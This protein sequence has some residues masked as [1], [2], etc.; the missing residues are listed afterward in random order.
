MLRRTLILTLFLAFTAIGVKP[1]EAQSDRWRH[2]LTLVGEQQLPEGFKH[3]DYVNPQ[4]PKA[5]VVRLG[6]QGTFDSFNLVV[7]GLRGQ[8]QSGVGL[9]YDTL[10]TQSQDE[11]DGAYGLLAEAVRYPDD[12]SSVTYRLR[13]SARWHDGLP[14]TSEDVIFS[15]EALKA[16]SPMFSS[17]YAHVTSAVASGPREITFSFSEKGNRELPYVVGQLPVLPK[18]WWQGT[19][20]AGKKRDITQSS[21]EPPLGS[22][23]YR[24]K[25]FEPGRSAVYERVAD[26]WG[27]DIP[28]N[29]GQNNFDEVSYEY[30]RDSTVLLEAFKA[31]RIDFRQENIARNWATA[32]DFPAALEGRVIKEEFPSRAMGIMQ[33]MVFNLRRDKFVDER[34]RQAFNLAFDFEE[35]NKILF[36]GLYERIDSYFFGTELASSGLPEGQELAILETVRDKV[37]ARI[38]STPFKNPVNG[39]P[40]AVRNNLREALDLMRQAGYELRGRQLVNTKTGQPF[41]AEFLTDDP[42]F[43]R[44]ALMYKQALEKIGISVS[45]RT[46]D[47]AQYQ[48][49]LRDFDFD[50][51]T[52][53]WAQTLS[54]GNEQS[55]FWGSKS[56]NSPGSRNVVGINNPAVD[57]L[58]D[59]VVF[60]KDRDELVAA[61]HALDRVLLA[62]SY[63][64][65]QWT[66]RK[67]RTARWNRFGHPERMPRYGMSA[68]PTIWWY[69]AELA[70]RT[71]T[72]K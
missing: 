31:N 1:S 19:N 71:R 47:A 64:V 21:L 7:A 16:N 18:H 38:F 54:P 3:F 28:V 30:Y 72:P 23:P 15:F 53:L 24:L 46:V 56:A 8:L 20:P 67:I 26:Y 55:D 39:N 63:V 32:Y 33:A 49:R 4:A 6:Q 10:M 42:S 58:I 69:D 34:V 61:T 5:G 70:A 29:V 45:V 13:E 27:K 11:I 57:M 52:N 35:V 17:Y 66:S 65:P 41:T 9:V 40:E 44:Y 36:Y 62:N 12:F 14:V 22:G 48:R 37:P 68:F 43:E 60:A 51:T 59:R 25:K 2:G 50:L